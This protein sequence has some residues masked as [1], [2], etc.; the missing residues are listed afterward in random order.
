MCSP[1]GPVVE[2]M[3]ICDSVS[4]PLMVMLTIHVA[5]VLIASLYTQNSHRAATRVATKQLRV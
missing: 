2:V 4:P 5:H 1:V 3:P